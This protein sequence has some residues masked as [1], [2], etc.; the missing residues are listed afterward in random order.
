MRRALARTISVAL[1][2]G[3]HCGNAGGSSNG[4]TTGAAGSAMAGSAQ[5]GQAGQTGSGGSAG[6]TGSTGSGV[7]GASGAAGASAGD[8]TGTTGTAS[9]GA[10]TGPAG[11]TGASGSAAGN[12]N[13]TTGAG[14]TTG[15]DGG[16]ASGSTSGSSSGHDAAASEGGGANADAGAPSDPAYILG[17]DVSS[18]QEAIA[19]GAKYYDDDGTQKDILALLKG[20]GFN[21]IRL[22]TFVDPTQS[23]PNP[24]G[25][26]FAP[27]STQGYGDITHVVAYAKLVKAAGLGFLLDFH[28][29]D[30][31][32]DPGKQIKPAAWTADGLTSFTTA[33]SSYTQDA[34]TQ[35]VAA[36]ARPDI[37]QVG[38]EITPGMDLTPGTALGPTSN[39]K[40]LAQ[41]LNAGIDA[42]HGVD[43][44]I[45]IM[46]HIDRGGDLATSTTWIT[47]AM[48]N[49]VKFDVFGESCYVAYQGQPSGWQ[50]TF[51][52]LAAKFPTLK[53]VMAEYNAD[54]SDNTELREA[55]DIIFQLPNHQGLGTFFWEPTESGAWGP[56]LFTT[57]GNKVTTIPASIDQYDQMKTAYG[58]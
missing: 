6:A 57:S 52:Q 36:G 16:A 3:V 46:L 55:N 47:N 49:G 53:F 34:I 37:V 43:P 44:T 42:I 35:L 11:G 27:Y 23:A 32:A 41:L 24:A 14:S 20:H 45:Q 30:Y 51:T 48:N 39:W 13:G 4:P 38:N 12:T 40:Q 17:A 10:S 56:G 22:R 26:T 28:Y 9:A 8:A 54:T 2:F 5:T 25:G 33:L 50:N 1:L 7:S 31:W 18:V 29:S 58:L 21:F 15:H 19:N